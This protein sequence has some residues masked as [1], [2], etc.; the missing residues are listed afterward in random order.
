MSFLKTNNWNTTVIFHFSFLS[1]KETHNHT[2]SINSS[3]PKQ[4]QANY[5]SCFHFSQTKFET[6]NLTNEEN[7]LL[8]YCKLSYF[9]QRK[10]RLFEMHYRKFLHFVFNKR[11]EIDNDAIYE[12]KTVP[13]K[14]NS[15]KAIRFTLSK[16]DSHTHNFCKQHTFL[17]SKT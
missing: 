9:Q 13:K 8:F 7:E 3:N 14:T 17:K 12:N 15:P 11:F 10:Q 2:L 16:Q 4:H 1:Q 6:K 5:F